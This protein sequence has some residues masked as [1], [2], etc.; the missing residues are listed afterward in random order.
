MIKTNNKVSKQ[1]LANMDIDK[2]LKDIN[3]EKVIGGEVSEKDTENSNEERTES[4]TA[5]VAVDNIT[6][7][8]DEK[9]KSEIWKEFIKNCD[10]NTYR[11]KKSNRRSYMIDDDIV[12]TLQHL[13][14]NKMAVSDIINAVMRSFITNEKDNLR[15]FLQIRGLLI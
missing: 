12:N 9:E 6:T 8:T 7:A 14:I 3:D 13:N 2:M 10:K 5:E 1:D 11:V 15:E 4:Q